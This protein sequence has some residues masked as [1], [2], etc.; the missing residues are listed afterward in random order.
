MFPRQLNT[1]PGIPRV[2][3][4][5]F[6][7]LIA[8]CWTAHAQNVIMDVNGATA[9]FGLYNNT[10]LY[11]WDSNS[12]SIWTT[13]AAG[14]NATSTWSTLGGGSSTITEFNLSNSTAS[15]AVQLAGNFSVQGLKFSGARNL[16][17]NATSSRV[18]TLSP[19]ATIETST[20]DWG[21]TVA[22]NVS[23]SGDFTKTG[24]GNL[25]LSTAP[26][27]GSVTVN[28]GQLWLGNPGVSNTSIHVSLNGTSSQLNLNNGGNYFVGNLSGNGTV[29]TSAAS[30][31]TLTIA[32]ATDQEFTGQIINQSA[33]STRL[34][35]I[36]KNGSSTLALSGNNTYT[37]ATV[38]NAGTLSIASIADG[39]ISLTGNYVSSNSVVT[40]NSTAGLS[41]NMTV[42]STSATARQRINSISGATFTMNAN[43][44]AAGTNV[45]TLVGF[46][47]GLGMSDSTATNLQIGNATLRYTGATAS[48]NRNFTLINGTAAGIDVSQAGTTLTMSGNAAVSTGAFNKLG[49]GTLV[50]SGN[51]SYSGATTIS[52]GT[53]SVS[54]L[55]NGLAVSNIGQSSNVAGNLILNGGTLQYT[56]AGVT[57]DRLFSLQSSSTIDASGT[58]ALNFTNTG[59]MGFNSGTAAKTLTLT[60]N[61][62]GANTLAAVIANNT[63]ATS[64]TKAG[65]GTWV[66]T[67]ANTYS[68]GTT[69]STGT[70][71]L[72]GAAGSAGSGSVSISSGAALQLANSAS[73]TITNNMSGAGNIVHTS[74][75]GVTATLSGNNTNTGAILSTGGGTLLFSGANALSTG[76]TSLNATSASTLSFVDGATRTITLGSS[77]ISLSSAA[78]SFD[79]DLSTSVSDRL[80]FGGA[81]SLSGINIVNLSFLNSLSGGQTWTLLTAAS[82]LDG[83][84]WSLGTYTNQPGYTFSLTSTATTLSLIASAGSSD[85][86]WTGSGGPSWTATNFSSTINGPASIPG[87]NL[88]SSSNVIFAGTGAGNLTTSL[89]ADYTINSLTVSTPE[90]AINGSNTIN[91]TSSSS[92]GIDISATGNTTIGANLA[93]N[94]GLSKSGTGTLTLNGSNT[95]SGGASITGG[96]VVIGTSTALGNAAGVVT[97]NPG[98]GNTT[99]VKIGAANLM[100]A[101][102]LVLTSGTTAIDTNS[103]NSTASGILSSTG[104]LTKLGAGTLL[105]SGNNSHSGPITITTGTLEIASTGRL[106]GGT[107]MSA[108]TN[109]A[110][111][112]YSGANDQT[113][114][115]VISGTGALIQNATST[116]TLSGNNTY[117]GTT[118]INAGALNIRDANALGSA[119]NGTI[120]ASGAALQL[121]G[122]ISVGA[123]ALT[124]SGNGVSNDGALRNIS[125]TNSYVGAITLNAATRINSDSGVLILSGNIGG[126]G[127]S[128][129]LGGAGTVT[130][131]GSNTYTGTTIISAGTLQI[132]NVGTTGNLSASSN[133]TNNGTLTFNR[134]NNIT[135]GTDFGSVISGTGALIQAGS[136]NLILSGANAYSGN[137][138]LNSGNLFINNSGSG[139]TSSAIG[140]GTLIIN[141]GTLNNT[142]GSLVTLSTNNNQIWNANFSF[143]GTNDLNLGTGNVTLSKDL[144]VTVNSG[145]NLTVGG[146]VSSTGSTPFTKQGSG[147][148]ILSGNNTYTGVTSIFA[149]TLSVSTLANGGAASGIGQSSNAASNLILAG[150]L[151]Y[152]GAAVSTDRL[153]QLRSSFT[154]DASG[155][156]ALNFTNTGSMSFNGA[157]PAN[158]LTLTGNNTGANTLAPVIGDNTGATSITK[159]GSGTW[160]LSGNNTYTGAT[161]INAGALNIQHANALGSTAGNTTVASGA[162]LQLQGSISVGAEALTLSGNGVSNDGALRNISGTNS[163]AGNITLGAAARINSDS[164]LLTLSGN[165]SGTQNLAVG[166]EGNIT[167]SGIIGTSTGSLVKDGNGTLTLSANNTY[168]GTTTINSGTLTL[169]GNGTLG[170]S[171]IT[172]TGGTLD[173]GGKSLTNTFGSLTG[174]TLSNGTLTNNG[175]NYDLQNGTVSAVLAG[176]NGVNKTGSGTVTLT[177]ATTFNG[178]TT[179][180]SGTLKADAANA[181]ANTSQ[182]VLNNGGSFLVTAE[183]AVNDNAAIHLN[184]GRMAMSGN[185]NETVG[186]LTLSANSTLDFSGFVGTLRFSGIGSWAAGANLAI[187]NW[188]GQTQHGTNYGTYP[189]SSNLV[190]TNNS[191]LSSNLANISFYSDSGVTSIGSGFE[192]GFTGGGT[193]IIAVPETETYFY[194]VAL[195]VGI[196][197]Q[198][199]R[200]RAKR[201]PLGGSACGLIQD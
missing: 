84:T 200:R 87:G 182:V 29:R 140:T 121:Q 57:T 148:L 63:G 96:T 122:G 108:I 197:I 129:T 184:G 105:L 52:A 24:A 130:L 93:G 163:Y 126:A 53:L 118:T 123:E 134:S 46:A 21:G 116:L 185:F 117:T 177:G 85:V 165:L 127:Q 136:G 201:K 166:G 145:S 98:T 86:Y 190:F 61:N 42:V 119:A 188:S 17:L 81:A 101:N 152:T 70:L 183:N 112:T 113:L 25:N 16:T 10:P 99:T 68:G 159:N 192:R 110:T 27:Q 33:L 180:N 143:N 23:L 173:L 115:G 72:S 189:N 171:T 149:G 40:A 97:L 95:Y 47:N 20:L 45:V 170:T 77:G 39:A 176:T 114:G 48:T 109:N 154:I 195:L 146:V 175:G 88:T 41:V 69:I 161:T 80:N 106:G 125:Q 65:T 187:W 64:L 50:F 55:A 120:V 174:G 164:G 2:R 1:T 168:S 90:V 193:E 37:G 32:P 92:S 172:L 6:A 54:T 196:V 102:N 111:F 49:N 30:N 155:T 11:V 28:A 83:G 162:A 5:F 103:F 137:T 151:R 179:V 156:G 31:Y 18:I 43:S 38:I 79:V 34:F 36:T 60:G 144:T 4:V 12:S 135:Q 160:V 75:A 44:S 67:G 147:T 142:S 78:L 22:D 91:I 158:T 186:A 181:L 14:T 56:G 131:T 141:G 59:S 194:A 178:T 66:L 73:T 167:V 153:F 191:T 15:T 51:H 26:Y 71:S 138:T 107:Y 13:S 139:G 198:F 82:G 150:T 74:G 124:L 62:T 169:S 76:L 94:A 157:P 100:L 199:I 132:G 8:T 3:I 19:G 128:L 133:I 35:N 89:G 9:G 58:G 7:L 104:T